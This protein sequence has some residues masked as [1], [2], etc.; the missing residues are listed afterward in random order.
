MSPRPNQQQL[1]R[2][3]EMLRA[4]ADRY[5][6]RILMHLA[7]REL[8]VGQ[9]S[10]IEGEKITTISAR[11]KVLFAARLVSRRRAGHTIIYAI[12]DTHVLNL[13][14]NAIAHACEAHGP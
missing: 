8:N 7:E 1:E 6:L 12:A 10:E 13:V 14:D 5:R 3:A 2:A 9:L 11:L 4:V